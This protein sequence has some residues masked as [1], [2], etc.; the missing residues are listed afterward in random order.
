MVSKPVANIGILGSCVTRDVF[1]LASMQDVNIALYASRTNFVSMY[2]KSFVEHVDYEFKNDPS[3]PF[4]GFRQRIAEWEL[5][6]TNLQNILEESPNLDALIVDVIDDRI[7]TAVFPDG[8][9]LVQ[10]VE[11]E[12]SIDVQGPYKHVCLILDDHWQTIWQ[13]HAIGFFSSV[14]ECNP[15]IK[16]VYHQAPF[17]FHTIQGNKIPLLPI[18]QHY[19]RDEFLKRWQKSEKRLIDTIVRIFPDAAVIKID[20]KYHVS[21][22]THRWGP[23]V[24]HYV[25]EYY[26]DFAEKLISVLRS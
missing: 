10:S 26:L 17:C 8:R 24:I 16:I 23:A 9:L 7:N 25:E 19:G 18:I 13:E 4:S 11:M 6:K 14:K 1:A 2:S 15:K 5:N 3:I 21:D 20:D 12:K 22:E